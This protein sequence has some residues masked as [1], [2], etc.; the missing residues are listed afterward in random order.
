MGVSLQGA[1]PTV[2]P[3]RFLLPE[4]P[5]IKIGQLR[6][7]KILTWLHGGLRGNKTKEISY[8]SFIVDAILKHRIWAIECDVY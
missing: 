2:I 7:T 1:V 5:Y 3:A 4:V 6:Y 8:L